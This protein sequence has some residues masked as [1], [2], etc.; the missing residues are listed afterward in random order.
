MMEVDAIA[1]ESI[2]Q[3]PEVEEVVGVPLNT[4]LSSSTEK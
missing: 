1:L 4:L 2:M 3:Y